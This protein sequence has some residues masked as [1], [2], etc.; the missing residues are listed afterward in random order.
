MLQ[1]IRFSL[2]QHLASYEAQ[3]H[4]QWLPPYKF[5]TQRQAVFLF[6]LTVYRVLEN[7][8]PASVFQ[9]LQFILSMAST[10]TSFL[11]V[12]L[13]TSLVTIVTRWYF[14]FSTVPLL[15]IHLRCGNIL[16]IQ[17]PLFSDPTQ[18]NFLNLTS[19]TSCCELRSFNVHSHA[20]LQG[21]RC[22]GTN[23]SAA[24]KHFVPF[25]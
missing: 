3:P 7:F 21:T 15:M 16:M 23:F 6:F 24:L 19:S 9:H 18:R 22:Y 13:S 25:T 14:D 12:T 17:S 2:L 4:F 10:Q 20:T 1:L 11:P 8:S 5:S